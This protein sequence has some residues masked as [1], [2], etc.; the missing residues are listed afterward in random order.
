MIRAD[1]RPVVNALL[2]WYAREGRQLPWRTTRD[3]YRILV[4]EIMLQQTQV[5][6]VLE[7]YRMFLR[8]FPTLRSLAHGRQRDVV[9]AWR[10]MGYNNRAVRLHRLARQAVILHSGR[11]PND[12][13]ALCS[14]PGIGEYT[15][16]AIRSSAFREPVPVIDVNVRRVLSRLFR[17]MPSPSTLRPEP[18]V[19][20][21]A[22]ALL[23]GRRTFEWNQ[24]LMDLGAT[25][26]TARAPRC[27]VC[28]VSAWCRSKNH[29]TGPSSR[30]TR[31]EPS[32]RGIPNRIYR[33][34]IVDLLRQEKHLA[35]IT[36]A[37]IG[38]AV[39]PGFSGRDRAWL[40]LLLAALTRDGLIGVR[41][42]GRRIAL[43]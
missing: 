38:R 19:V 36:A 15:A 3:P 1:A 9:M 31:R 34:R 43:K 41:G 35:G 7:K 27:P 28:P 37:T 17:R 16:A 42:N 24:A 39:Y 21:L 23:P 30:K 4:S 18:E 32:R 26:C 5:H 25:V 14:L 11:V 2:H 10:G 20:E 13:A 6:R 22:H 33:G 8:R 12:H 29:M 40:N